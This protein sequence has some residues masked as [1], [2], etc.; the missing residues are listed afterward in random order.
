[1]VRPAQANRLRLAAARAYHAAAGDL[2]R[3]MRSVPSL[4]RFEV[5]R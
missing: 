4:L 5:R 2:P 1:M 3:L